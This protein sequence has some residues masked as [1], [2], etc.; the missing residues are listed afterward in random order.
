MV[1]PARSTELGRGLELKKGVGRGVGEES[2]KC[3]CLG[4]SFFFFERGSV[5]KDRELA[6]ILS[7]GVTIYRMDPNIIESYK[8]VQ[9]VCTKDLRSNLKKS[10]QSS[11]ISTKLAQQPAMVNRGSTGELATWATA[12]GA[13][14]A[15]A[16]KPP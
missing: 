1:A 13:N 16:K 14:H 3:C 12:A 4:I 5:P 8:Q 10:I 9:Q 2:D 6:L 15:C 7:G 11:S